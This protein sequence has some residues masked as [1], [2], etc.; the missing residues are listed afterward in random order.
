MGAEVVEGDDEAPRLSVEH[1]LD[2]IGVRALHRRSAS[3]RLGMWML[4]PV[5]KE[6]LELTRSVTLNLVLQQ[7]RLARHR[8]QGHG[9]ATAGK[10]LGEC[11]KEACRA[12]LLARDLD[13][14]T[15]DEGDEGVAGEMSGQATCCF[16][17]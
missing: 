6:L 14:G 4:H 8:L 2:R 10:P 3:L 1:G 15:G 17:P 11:R 9:A 5:V 13:G 7:R 12:G 16:E